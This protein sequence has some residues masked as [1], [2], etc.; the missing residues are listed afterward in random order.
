MSIS[1]RLATTGK[2]LFT[3]SYSPSANLRVWELRRHFWQAENT[4]AF[5]AWTLFYDHQLVEDAALVSAYCGDPPSENIIFHAICRELR[6][7]TKEENIAIGDCIQQRQRSH[8]WTILSKGIVL[9]SLVPKGTALEAL[10]VK[11]INADYPPTYDTGPLPDCVTMLLLAQCD[12]NI[13]G[14]PS[15]SPLGTAIRR[16]EEHT[17]EVLLQFQADPQLREEREELPLII[18]IARGATKC[19]KILLD[20]WAD[21]RP[22]CRRPL[23]DPMGSSPVTLDMQLPWI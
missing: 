2:E 13:R 20:Y 5:F 18:A 12:P 6:P 7:P 3:E 9:T 8:L 19:V 17:V 23:K 11:A 1:I 4:A 21:P 16:G 14:N 22:Q 15:L 10:L